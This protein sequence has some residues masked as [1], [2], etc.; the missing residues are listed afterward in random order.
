M[1][2]IDVGQSGGG[3]AARDNPSGS[4]SGNQRPEEPLRR[5]WIEGKSGVT[6]SDPALARHG[7]QPGTTGWRHL[8]HRPIGGRAAKRPRFGSAPN[9]VTKSAGH[10]SRRASVGTMTATALIRR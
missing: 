2:R 5:Q 4:D 7:I 10:R 3:V 9:R 8:W 6:A 1:T